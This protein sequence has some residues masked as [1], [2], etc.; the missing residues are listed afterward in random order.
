MRYPLRGILFVLVVLFLGIVAFPHQGLAQLFFDAVDYG[1]GSYPRFVV[2]EDFDGDGALDLAVV[3][4]YSEDVSVL[5]GRGDGTFDESASYDVG[6]SPY[7]I[8]AEDFNEDEIVDL[9][10]SN[11]YYYYGYISLLIGNGDGTFAEAVQIETGYK[12]RDM[13]AADFNGDGLAD[14]AVSFPSHSGNVRILLGR[15]DGT[16]EEPIPYQTKY[17]S[18]G[19]ISVSDFNKDGLL[20]LA[21]ACLQEGD[22]GGVTIFLGAGDG[23]FEVLDTIYIRDMVTFV[24]SADFN[25]DADIDLAI[26][27]GVYI[28]F[29]WGQGTGYF[30]S[31]GAGPQCGA[32]YS[33][34]ADIDGDGNFDIVCFG[35]GY[36]LSVC[37]GDGDGTFTEDGPYDVGQFPWA[38]AVGDFDGNGSND[39]AVVD[40]YD[41][42]VS[43]LINQ[44]HDLDRDGY[45]DEACGGVDCDDED[46]S[47]NPEALEICGNGIDDDCD[48][49]DDQADDD[50]DGYIDEACGGDDCNDEWASVNPGVPEDCD[51]HYD[52]NCNGILD[53]GCPCFIS[54]CLSFAI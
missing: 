35:G 41:D 9:V 19:F 2:A 30:K 5:L 1:V 26:F 47:I 34:V 14:L 49:K 48:G 51:T 23:T 33:A 52:D 4:E 20:D 25:G 28:D 40:K 13:A 21:V 31:G 17:T 18:S 44:C 45:N 38:P 16:F 7:F 24:G 27:A 39:V 29:L 43:I 42:T 53:E 50:G 15:G 46:P 22:H 3:N 32:H 11:P 10:V 37:L 8:V 12:A 54:N 36:Y 6:S